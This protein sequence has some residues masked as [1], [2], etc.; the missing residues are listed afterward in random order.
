MYRIFALI[1]FLI[2]NG[3]TYAQKFDPIKNSAWIIEEL[4]IIDLVYNEIDYFTDQNPEDSLPKM[5]LSDNIVIIISK[6]NP[7]EILEL[8]YG[9]QGDFQVLSD[10]QLKWVLPKKVR[11]LI[12]EKDYFYITDDS[13]LL[14]K[15][16]SKEMEFLRKQFFWTNRDVY[17][18]SGSKFILDKMVFRVTSVGGASVSPVYAASISVGNEFLGYPGDSKGTM[19]VGFLGEFYEIGFQTPIPSFVPDDIFRFEI[20]K[21]ENPINSLQG[22]LGWFGRVS[23]FGSQIQLGFSDVDGSEMVTSM[24]DVQDSLYYDYMSLSY[25]AIIDIFD[26]RIL[27][28]GH[29]KAMLGLGSYRISHKTLNEDGLFIDR[30]VDKSGL[31]LEESYSVFPGA[32]IRLD[33]VTAMNEA[34]D[35]FP[36]LQLFTQINAYEGNKSWMVGGSASIG[37]IGFDVTYKK[38]IDEVDWAPADEAFIS[39]NY[40]FDQ[41]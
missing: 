26:K 31:E 11:K 6:K 4:A 12:V 22:S 19:D 16:R 14:S 10:N 29:V 23:M 24:Q 27:N 25:S 36:L 37:K 2:L 20:E 15:Q 1:I 17:L 8:W 9:K 40:F 28:L 38:S 32:M 21:G 30:N 3:L 41:K 39:V 33:F 35:S 5:N 34:S 7:Y 18:S 13:F